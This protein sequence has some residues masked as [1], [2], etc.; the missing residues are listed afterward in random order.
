MV[1]RASLLQKKALSKELRVGQPRGWL[2]RAV[3]AELGKNSPK[4]GQERGPEGTS[5][6][7]L[8]PE[9]IFHPGFLAR[10]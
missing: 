1:N 9:F 8:G 4:E 6:I 2:R 10:N 7:S 3:G 5:A